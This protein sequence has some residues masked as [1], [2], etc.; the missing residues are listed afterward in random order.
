VTTQID[1]NLVVMQIIEEVA[2]KYNLAALLHEKP[3]QVYFFFIIFYFII[4]IKG[5]Q[6]F[7]KTQQLVHCDGYWYQLV[8]CEPSVEEQWQQRRLPNRDV[9]YCESS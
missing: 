1:Q 2:V 9:G 7:W 3:F 4:L 5:Y 6:W 8:E